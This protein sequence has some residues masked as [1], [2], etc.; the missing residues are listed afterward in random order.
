[1]LC[2][3]MVQIFVRYSNYPVTVAPTKQD[4]ML[5]AF[6]NYEQSSENM[7][8]PKHASTQNMRAPK[9]AST[10]TC[11]HPNMRAPNHVSTQTCEHLKHAS[12]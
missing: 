1:M 6:R 2:F 9:H 12:T 7:Q 11:E 4:L 10:Q 3:K 8:A 5:S